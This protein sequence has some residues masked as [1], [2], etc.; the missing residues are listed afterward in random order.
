MELR[1]FRIEQW[2]VAGMQRVFIHEIFDGM[3][4]NFQGPAA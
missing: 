3:T 2:E 4:Q 1:I